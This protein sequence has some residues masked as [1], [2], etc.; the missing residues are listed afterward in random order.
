LPFVEGQAPRAV[1]EPAREELPKRPAPALG[2][3]SLSVSAPQGPTLPF[4]ASSQGDVPPATRENKLARTRVFELPEHLRAKSP[5]A[6]SVP[7]PPPIVPLTLAQYA[8]LCVELAAAPNRGA[9][10]LA[11]Y[12]LTTPQRDHLD[13]HFQERFTREPA[14]RAEWERAC[15]TYRAWLATRSPP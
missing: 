13:R 12:R 7:A 10:I 3:T 14:V 9:E 8:S 2:G 15:A 5:A 11:R 1:A 4:T 6:P